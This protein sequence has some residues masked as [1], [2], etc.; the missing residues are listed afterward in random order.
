MP[1]PDPPPPPPWFDEEKRRGPER[2]RKLPKLDPER[3][4]KRK[5]KDTAEF[6]L[7]LGESGDRFV[8]IR[9]FALYDQEG[10]YRGV[11]EVS[12]DVTDIRA[13]KGK[14]RLLD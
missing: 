2:R 5:E 11:V 7:S 6:W 14:K 9:Y 3:T 4:R 8:H 13:L 10:A 12:Q 1:K